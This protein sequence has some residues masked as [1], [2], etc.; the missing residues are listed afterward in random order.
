M[1]CSKVGTKSVSQLFL[2]DSRCLHHSLD[3]HVILHVVLVKK[4]FIIKF[5]ATVEETDL[6]HPRLQITFL[7]ESA[8]QLLNVRQI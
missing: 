5:F 7:N 8:F 4:E 6:T 1:Y 3:D 2:D